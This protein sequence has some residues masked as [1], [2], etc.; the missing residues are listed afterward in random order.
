MKLDGMQLAGSFRGENHALPTIVLESTHIP[1]DA[2]MSGQGEYR[3]SDRSWALRVRGD[4][5]PF[6]PIEGEELSFDLDL[7]GTSALVELRLFELQSRDGEFNARGSYRFNQPKPLHVAVKLDNHPTNAQPNPA[8]LLQGLV[9]G[10]A[11]LD[12]TI[13]PMQLSLGG[14][15]HG[16]KVSVVGRTIGDLEIKVAGLIDSNKADVR[17]QQLSALGGNWFL[18]GDYDFAAALLDIGI[19]VT[20]LPLRNLSQI[21]QT[22][23][24][25]GTL[26][27]EWDAYLYGLRLDPRRVRL[28][29]GGSIAALHAV[30][31]ADADEVKFGTTLENGQLRIDPIILKRGGQG[32]GSAVL[33]LNIDN[34]R[35]IEAQNIS[36][37]QLA[38]RR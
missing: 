32:T 18:R 3:L 11:D 13:S 2:Q 36:A 8:L 37:G 6:H 30:R 27:G 33:T 16:A 34:P 14:N 20:D 28:S 15:L 7:S 10:E 12:G 29:G 9:D 35:H 5:W 4:H 17:T 22:D 1:A 21:T 38:P 19:S 26:R 23:P 31:F 24:I 25:T